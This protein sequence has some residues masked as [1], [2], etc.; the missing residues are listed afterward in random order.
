MSRYTSD[1]DTLRQMIS[2]SIPQTISSGVTV[3]VIL[4]T[5]I[6]TSWILTLVTLV[7][8]AGIMAITVKVVGKASGYFVFPSEAT[9]R[10]P[11]TTARM[12]YWM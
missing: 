6:C 2:Q 10:M 4:I 1:I 12:A 11:P 3:A 8:V 9:T 5:M 7:T